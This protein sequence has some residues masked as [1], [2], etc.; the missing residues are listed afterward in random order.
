MKINILLF[1]TLL[2]SMNFAFAQKK[3]QKSVKSAEETAIDSLNNSFTF[4]QGKVELPEGNISLNIPKGFRFLDKK[5][6]EKVLFDVYGNPRSEGATRGLIFPEDHGV[7]DEGGFFFNV[8]YEAMGFVKDTDADKI[9]YAELL[10]KMKEN[11]KEENE[12][13]KKEGYPEIDLVGWANPP[14]YDKEH[15]VLHWAKELRFGKSEENTLNYD[16]RVLGRKGVVS[17]NAVAGMAELELVKANIGSVLNIVQYKEGSRYADFNPGIDQVA[18]VTIGGLIAGKLLAK[19][20]FFVII[21]KFIKPILLAFGGG[22]AA[23]WRW[24]TGKKKDEEQA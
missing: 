3:A 4:Q 12:S 21:L 1:I 17:L 7:G 19:A 20:G 22:G 13:R 9:D 24:I 11:G 16:V 23:L 5:Q 6:A 2:C 8:S 14:F 15:K 18:A 10:T